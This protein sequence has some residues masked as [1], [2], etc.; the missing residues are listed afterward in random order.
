MPPARRSRPRVVEGRGRRAEE[1]RTRIGWD[2][3]PSLGA[4]RTTA[5]RQLMRRSASVLVTGRLARDR[6]GDRAP[7]RARR[8]GPRRDRLLPLG[9]GRRG[10]GRGAARARRRAGARARQRRARARARAGARARPARRP[11]P[12]RRHRRHPPRPRD[13]G[14][15]L[16]L[17]AERERARAA[18][19]RPCRRTGDAARARRSSRSPASARPRARELRARR[20]VEGGARGPR[21]LPRRRARPGGIR[22]NAVSGGV[23]ETGALEH[24]PNRE[25]MLAIGAATRPAGSSRRTTSRA[26]SL[27]SAGPTRR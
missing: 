24:F 6:Q 25:A 18:L 19:A 13:R 17:D 22:V 14:Q 21:P 8:R 16:G 20:H 10:D 5:P 15:A 11:R 4:G 26:R 12:Q 27:S 1:P 3:I 7:L 2:E 23:V 9:R